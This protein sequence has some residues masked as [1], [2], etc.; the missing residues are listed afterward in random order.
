MIFW[1]C[2]IIDFGIMSTNGIVNGH[3]VFLRSRLLKWDTLHF[4]SCHTIFACI[5]ITNY[6]MCTYQKTA[7]VYMP[8]MKTIQSTIWQEHRYAYISH[9]WH[10]PLNKY[11]SHITHMCPTSLL[12]WST[13]KLHITVNAGPK[14]QQ[15]ATGTPPITARN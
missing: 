15:S 13:Y 6:L 9:Y 2:D 8:H 11:T 4:W 14:K 12:L 5:D 7:S 10:M 1:S 3:T